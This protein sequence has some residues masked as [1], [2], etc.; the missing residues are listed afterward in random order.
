[1]DSSLRID[2]EAHS[3]RGFRIGVNL[4][5]WM[6]PPKKRQDLAPWPSSGTWHAGFRAGQ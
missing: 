3:A 1:M 2:C 6:T 4:S 5:R